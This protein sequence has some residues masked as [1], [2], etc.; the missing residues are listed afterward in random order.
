MPTLT[1][2]QTVT[3]QLSEGEYVTVSPDSGS[4][5]Q[6]S[7]RGVSG[8]PLQTPSTVTTQATFGPYTESGA[9]SVYCAAGSV[10]YVVL[11]VNGAVTPATGDTSGVADDISIASAI[12]SAG[13]GATIRLSAGSTYYTAGGWTLGAGQ[14]LDLNGATVKRANQITT[15]TATSLTSGVTTSFVVA[16]ASLF[17][18][19]CTIVAVNG[20]QYS[21]AA[22]ISNI[23][24]NTITISSPFSVGSAST[25]SI[26]NVIS[27]TVDSSWTLSGTTTIAKVY[28]TINAINAAVVRNGTID[29]NR[30]SWTAAC[31][32]DI[33]AEL[34]T[35]DTEIIGV[36]IKEAPG[37]AIM[38]SAASAA[39]IK[40]SA[41]SVGTRRG[42]VI[43]RCRIHD[44]NGNGIHLSGADHTIIDSNSCYNINEDL[45]VGHVGGFITFSYGG[46]H[47]R[48]VNNNAKR[49]YAFAGPMQIDSESR[50]LIQGNVAKQMQRYGLHGASTS[51]YKSSDIQVIGNLFVDCGIITFT[52]QSAGTLS[53]CVF[54]NNVVIGTQVQVQRASNFVASGNVIDASVLAYL[55]TTS[56]PTTITGAITANVTTSFVVGASPALFVGQRV[57][58]GKNGTLS[59]VVVISN[60]AGTTIDVTP[61]FDVSLSAGATLYIADSQSHAKLSAH[62]TTGNT[63]FTC[64]DATLF[65]KNQW[66]TVYNSSADNATTALRIS[67]IDY[68]TG[69]ISVDGSLDKT[70]T[71]GT[72]TAFSSWAPP[73]G[74]TVYVNACDA[75][76]TSNQVSG[77]SVGIQCVSDCSDAIISNNRVSKVRYYS[78][79]GSTNSSSTELIS[80]N[81]VSMNTNY[82]SSVAYGI[83]ARGKQRVLNNIVRSDTTVSYGILSDGANAMFDGNEIRLSSG[84]AM[85]LSG[86][87]SANIVRDTR[88]NGSITNSGAGNT[89]EAVQTIVL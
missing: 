9:L 77:G 76:I 36:E 25:T 88:S 84:S 65:Y 47:V 27:G 18:I 41:T 37:E 1:K 24:G 33:L 71:A 39:A 80:N 16:D 8:S 23:V 35:G 74:T 64:N 28:N 20:Y 52:G 11:S 14:T 55:P 69:V 68:S 34:L 50:V 32:W 21:A 48:V 6:V 5:A 63:S 4:A 7:T 54:A 38:Q 45:G 78:I 43:A 85:V 22:V 57:Q 79:M 29:G 67:A 82:S 89:V 30:S 73:S 72:S 51:P 62:V 10:A 70:H 49:A 40:V 13:Y 15:T 46:D 83:W 61:A 31:K 56:T 53:R 44:C 19:G 58:A 86:T 17:T 42:K 81:S 75:M 87:T 59:S 66:V 26:A 2:G 12:S 60:V 3:L